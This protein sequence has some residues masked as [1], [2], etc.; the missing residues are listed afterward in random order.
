MSRLPGLVVKAFFAVALALLCAV[1]PLAQVLPAGFAQAQ[2]P[3]VMLI[4]L[5]FL[6]KLLIDTFFFDHYRP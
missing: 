4:L 6:G 1:A 2:V 5:C 3:V